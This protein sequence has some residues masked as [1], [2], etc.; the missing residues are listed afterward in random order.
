[1]K[2]YIIIFILFLIND[3]SFVNSLYSLVRVHGGWPL[4]ED[5]GCDPNTWTYYT[6]SAHGRLSSD[7]SGRGDTFCCQ[8]RLSPLPLHFGNIVS[9]V[10]KNNLISTPIS[11]SRVLLQF[12]TYVLNTFHT[13]IIHLRTIK[14]FFK[15][16]FEMY[17]KPKAYLKQLMQ[18]I[19]SWFS[20]CPC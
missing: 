7:S 1:M 11:F 20:L 12:V 2:Y 6:D 4:H 19:L 15:I 8:R 17:Y 9:Y 13:H 5:N 16:N 18:Y 14:F 10:A 3:V